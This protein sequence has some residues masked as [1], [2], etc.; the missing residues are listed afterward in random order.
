MNQSSN[1]EYF[2]WKFILALVNSIVSNKDCIASLSVL[3][4][5]NRIL[6]IS[7]RISRNLAKSTILFNKEVLTFLAF[8]VLEKH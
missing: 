1:L 3:E 6:E 5:G 2:S 7:K 4:A 8:I